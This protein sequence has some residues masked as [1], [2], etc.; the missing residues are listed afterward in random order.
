[1]NYSGKLYGR[2]QGIC[3]DTGSTTG[4]WD[5]MEEKIKSLKKELSILKGMTKKTC[6]KCN[7]E[8]ELFPVYNDGPSITCFYC[9]GSGEVEI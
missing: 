7:G 1:M 8:G 9:D 5:R 3:F 6:P 4:D 2:V